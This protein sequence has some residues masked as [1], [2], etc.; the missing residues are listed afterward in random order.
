MGK[1]RDNME[2][3]KDRIIWIP[4]AQLR[5]AEWNYKLDEEIKQRKLVEQIRKNGILETSLVRE[6][7]EELYEIVD[8]NHRYD[9]Y[10]ELNIG[11]VPCFTL[12]V[13]GVNEAKR[14]AIEKNETRFAADPVKLGGLFKDISM[15][16]L[17]PDLEI[18]MPYSEEEIS[19][20]TKLLDFDWN[21]FGT[22]GGE[23][24]PDR[25][26]ITFTVSK[27]LYEEWQ[28]LIAGETEEDIFAQAIQALK[29]KND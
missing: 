28:S 8:G 23:A 29:S 1:E 13:I 18:T 19:S 11:S 27:E 6:L 2:G 26:R 20:M 9:V 5:K 16:F 7:S 22:S 21:Q 17:P 14:I 25:F 12:G 4:F 15:E 10:N 24:K 3:L